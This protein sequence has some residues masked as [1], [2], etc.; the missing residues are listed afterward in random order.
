MFL[1]D[2]VGRFFLEGEGET[3]RTGPQPRYIKLNAKVQMAKWPRLSSGS[4]G[5]WPNCFPDRA[6]G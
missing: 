3:D 4:E 1:K 6:S 5:L 2:R